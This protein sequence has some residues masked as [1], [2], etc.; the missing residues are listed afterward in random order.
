[1]AEMVT[2]LFATLGASG[3]AA[4]GSSLGGAMAASGAAAAGASAAGASALTALSAGT[5]MISG[6]SAYAQ[7]RQQAQALEDQAASER[8]AAT[9]EL[10][11]AQQKATAIQNQYNQ[12]VADQFAVASASGYD[13]S[14][15]SVVA[16]RQFAQTQA[17]TQISIVQ[18]GGQMN[19]ALRR[20]RAWQDQNAASLATESGAITAVQK[21]AQGLFD[22]AS[23][24]GGSGA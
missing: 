21:V 18:N 1:M 13:V 22:M 5:S 3:A 23:I 2:T 17:D 8:M 14:S 19:A 24:G 11:D 6:L 7:G 12:V 10:T 4:G 20:A 9:G 15:G 16:A